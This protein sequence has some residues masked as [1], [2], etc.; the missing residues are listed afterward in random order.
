MEKLTCNACGQKIELSSAVARRLI[1]KVT[2][3]LHGVLDSPDILL[4]G[5]C[6]DEIDNWYQK[7][8]STMTYDNALQKFRTKTPRELVKEYQNVFNSFAKF[9]REHRKR[10]K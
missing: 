7:T 8:V 5:S 4:C 2:V 3:E 10:T 1:P 6:S 9:K